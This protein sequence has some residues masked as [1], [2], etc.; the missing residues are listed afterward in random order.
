MKAKP[1]LL[2]AATLL[3]LLVVTFVMGGQDKVV[4]LDQQVAEQVEPNKDDQSDLS[5]AANNE[6]AGTE[7]EAVAP[8]EVLTA[9]EN[10]S[11][12]ELQEQEPAQL[13]EQAQESQEQ[14]SSAQSETKKDDP[15]KQEANANSNSNESKPATQ[16]KPTQPPVAT[17]K[18]TNDKTDQYLTDPVPEGKPEPVEW[19]D[20]KV[21]EKQALK[22]TLAVSAATILNNMDLFNEDKLEVLP[23]DG[24]IY[25][26]QTVTFYEGESVFDVLLREMKKNKIHLEFVMTPI[27]N[28][29]YIEGINNLYE[30]DCGELSGWM[31]KVND[32]FP[33]YGASRYQLQSGDEIEWMYTC[34]LGR[35]IGGDGVVKGNE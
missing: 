30:F 26:K 21:D 1:L 8:E 7:A 32:W 2:L 3:V 13:D 20:V 16:V 24:V 34:D 25:A 27:Y 22:A 18:P 17:P 5:N 35:D 14:D 15:V 11:T 31:Y 4:P 12:N 10:L 33:N 19:Q 29:H 28:S 6:N 9:N 23:S